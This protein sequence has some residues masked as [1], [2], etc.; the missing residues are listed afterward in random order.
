MIPLSKRITIL[1]AHLLPFV[2]NDAFGFFFAGTSTLYLLFL[3]CLTRKLVRLSSP[4]DC[5]FEFLL[6]NTDLLKAAWFYY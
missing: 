5:K 3:S 6:T 2:Q 4:H 1:F